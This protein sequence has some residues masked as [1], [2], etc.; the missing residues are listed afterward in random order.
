MLNVSKSP[1]PD[2]QQVFPEVGTLPD[3][4]HLIPAVT[5]GSRETSGETP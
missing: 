4:T 2:L 5:I 3:R 1:A